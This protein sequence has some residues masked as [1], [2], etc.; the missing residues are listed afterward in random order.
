ML[1]FLLAERGPL[2]DGDPARGLPRDPAAPHDEATSSAPPSRASPSSSRP[3]LDGLDEVDA[4]DVESAPPAASSGRPCGARSSP[5]SSADR[6]PSPAGG[7]GHRARSRG[8]RPVRARGAPTLEAALRL[9]QLLSGLRPRPD[10]WQLAA[11]ERRQRPTAR[12]ARVSALGCTTS[13]QSAELLA[14]RPSGNLLATD[15]NSWHSVGVWA[16]SLETTALVELSTTR[17]FGPWPPSAQRSGRPAF[18][19]E[20]LPKRSIVGYG[21]GDFANN[22]AFTLGHDLPALLLHRR[23]GHVRCGGRDDVLRR[24]AVGRRDRHLRRPPRRPDHDAAGQVPPLHPLRWGAAAVPQRADLPR[25]GRVRRGDQAPVRL[26]DLRDP[27]AV[28]LAGE[29]PLRL[30]R[31]GD[32][33]VG[34]R[35]GQARR[36]AVLRQRHRR[37]RPHLHHRAEDLRPPRRE[38][39]AQLGGLPRQVQSI[40]TQTTLLFIL[41]GSI[42]YLLTVSWCREQ[43]VRTQPRVSA[44]ETWD[45]L[46]HNKPL[47]VPLRGELLLPHRPL[48]RRRRL[49]LLRPVRPRRHQVARPDHPGQHRH[50]DRR[51]PLHPQ[52]RRPARQE[53]ALPVLRAVHRRRRPGPLLHA[54]PERSPPP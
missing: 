26:P 45:T 19:D 30:A 12:F 33:P 36:L 40:F 54:R 42:A 5:E 11:P 27:R 28:L 37:H 43:V 52:A 51:A 18:A 23:R 32:D 41:I 49:G 6:S 50:L 47:G 16:P 17:K 4:R 48:R 13:A 20:R 44:R 10:A 15:G 1:P 31:L 35:A 24:A 34:Q 53:A 21:L 22:L 7:R 46:R 2:W 14:H 3:I 8:A 29:H 9:S 39:D 38:D 25:A